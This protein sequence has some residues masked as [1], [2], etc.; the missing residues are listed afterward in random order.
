[1][2]ILKSKRRKEIR[3]SVTCQIF[4][5]SVFD[6]TLQ[7]KY[8]QKNYFKAF[9]FRLKFVSFVEF[10]VEKSAEKCQTLFA[11]KEKLHGGARRFKKYFFNRVCVVK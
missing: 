2:K 11:T 1:M 6:E 3:N 8:S 5:L 4:I 7:Y 9:I 10:G